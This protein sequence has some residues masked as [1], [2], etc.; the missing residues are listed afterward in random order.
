M[1]GRRFLF[2][3]D[4]VSPLVSGGAAS[5]VMGVARGLTASGAS[6]VVLSLASPAEARALPGFAR[7]LRT[8]KVG[9]GE[10]ARELDFYEGKAPHGG[11]AELIVAGAV[12]SSRG[13][14]ALFMAEALKA[15][16][17]EGWSSPEVAVAWGETA[18]PALAASSAAVRV[19]VLPSGH[20]GEELPEGEAAMLAGAG[21]L[22]GTITENRLL[23]ALGAASANAVV[24][25]SPSSARALESD[26]CLVERAADEPVLAL[27]FGC[28]DPMS[29]PEHDANLAANFSAKAPEG[30]GECRKALIRSRSLSVG[31]RT[32][33]LGVAPLRRGKGGDVIL[34]V[35]GALNSIDVALLI[36]GEGDA[37]L[38]D[39]ARR[40]AIQ[41]PG[42]W[43]FLDPS[44]SDQRLLRAAADA[45]LFGDAD[46]RVSQAP[47]LAQ[48]YGAMPIAFDGGASR[49]YLVDYDPASATGSAILYGALDR[50]E[51]VAAVERAALLRESAMGDF[52]LTK[53]LMLAAPRWAQTATIFDELCASLA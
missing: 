22:S 17:S 42:R 28:D 39:Q 8:V 29:D 26:R 33:L 7:R 10:A 6:V 19:F 21:L 2:V 53:S 3:S 51:I 40:L 5:A 31:P 41:N 27:R 43:A 47:G 32:V 50:H 9:A 1:P 15:L 38:L 44:D 12:G 24:A 36:P 13:E 30:K 25:P 48:L 46:D 16:S 45:V 23:S 37:D 35:L 34:D 52:S 20:V 18:A 4:A 11:T 49:D 14:S